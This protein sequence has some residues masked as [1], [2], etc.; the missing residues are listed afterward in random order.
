MGVWLIGWE[1]FW[2]YKVFI[3][4]SVM[5]DFFYVVLVCDFV[6]FNWVYKGKDIFFG[7][8]FVFF[9]DCFLFLN[10]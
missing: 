5:L 7:L 10:Y 8:D 1:F 6:V 4:E 9:F 3:V 2:D